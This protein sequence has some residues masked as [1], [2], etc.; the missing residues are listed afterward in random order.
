M[1]FD[2]NTAVEA[3]GQGKSN[4]VIPTTAF[5]IS[6]AQEANQNPKQKPSPIASFLRD[7]F[8]SSPLEEIQTHQYILDNK[9]KIP[10][11][12]K[13]DN[14]KTYQKKFNE[15]L[16][17]REED[18]ARE[19]VLRQVEAPMQ[20]AIGATGMAAPIETATMVG[21]FS[22]ADHFFN[23]RRWIE[24]KAP[25][26]PPV[27]KDVV[28]ILDFVAKGAVIGGGVI[29]A[30]KFALERMDNLN[31]P[32]AVTITP[33][34][35]AEI[36][37]SPTITEPLGIKPEQ[38]DASV[39]S[40]T[41]IQIPMENV[42]DL[43]SNK[44]WDKIQEK[45]FSEGKTIK[46][47]SE[48]QLLKQEKL[49]TKIVDEAGNPLEVYH[50]TQ[51]K[52]ENFDLSKAW[53]SS[54]HN[55]YDTAI[56]FS[57]DKDVAK[58]FT[59]Q[60]VRGG[61]AFIKKANLEVK[62]P[63]SVQSTKEINKDLIDKLKAEGYDGIV[64]ENSGFPN[65]PSKE[66]VVFDPSQVKSLG[67]E[68]LPVKELL[69]R[70]RSS[71]TS[72]SSEMGQKTIEQSLPKITEPKTLETNRE[73]SSES[74]PMNQIGEELLKSPEGPLPRD[75]QTSEEASQVL[76]D[77]SK[78]SQQQ[79]LPLEKSM[80]TPKIQ[81]NLKEDLS[82]GANIPPE[83]PTVK[84]GEGM[85]IDPVQK[86]IEALKAA[87]PVRNQQESIYTKE[88]AQR[89]A[90]AL[91]MRGKAGGEKGFFAE[92]SQLKGEMTK[93]EFESIRSKLNQKDIDHL[94]NMVTDEPSLGFWEQVTART[95]LGKLMG[96]HG[97]KVPTKGELALL[98]KVFGNELV[99]ALIN[100]MPFW[101]K[102]KEWTGQVLNV[103][104]SIMSS[105]DLSAPLRQGVFLVGRKEFLPAFKKMFGYFAKEENLKALNEDIAR[106]PN[107][108]L[109]KDSGLALTDMDVML[110]AREEAFMSNL[111]EKIPVVGKGI[112]ASG[113]AYVG[114]LN[115]LRADVF[116]D[117]I[118]KSSDLGLNP[119]ENRDLA[120]DI[121]MFVNTATGRG[122]L[123]G[124][125]KA[126]TQLNTIFFSP[127][128]I[129]SRLTLLNPLYYINSKPFVRNEAIKS[130]LTFTG[131]VA[132]VLALAKLSGA[133]VGT[134]IRSSDF[135]K[136]IIGRT[137]IDIM[138]GFQQYMRMIG[139][140]ATGKY[141]SSTT[142]RVVTL[143][144]GY[145]PLTRKEILVRQFESKLAPV[146]SFISTVLEG[147]TWS[148]EKVKVTEEI[149]NRLTPMVLSTLVEL[150]EEDPKLFPVGLL[151][152]FGVGV[153]TYENKK[154]KKF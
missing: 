58:L 51:S 80:N 138:G 106:S 77:V 100:K 17:P 33:E 71:A 117:L 23:A 37:R 49:D 3:Q 136:I 70:T 6:T 134:D 93:A 75:I 114:F 35:A 141:V 34:Q 144:E 61:E 127:R 50:G 154:P 74:P 2:I 42:I 79:S 68:T 103:P 38:V 69:E 11:V 130:L 8:K 145:R 25:Q 116:N 102:M 96:E 18:I 24:D 67:D 118:K 108:E 119:K 9:D 140:L 36:K 47:S 115:K 15:F 86:V 56:H 22:I 135:G 152:I 72:D 90:R 122:D 45:L 126:A 44:N 143:G 4:S 149:K 133:N 105:F 89:M 46:E 123:A 64:V 65:K 113:R 92:L 5:N 91:S 31:L 1:P 60:D 21:G 87:K 97:G 148:G 151:G 85:P 41:P 82:S 66:Y 10:K 14:Y 137:R 54:G 109:M 132:T 110:E 94:F 124:F 83:T 153:Q 12:S 7:I 150:A 40:G 131:T 112:R 81:M 88:R 76:G 48:A 78:S 39:N 84:G 73:A 99:E 57:S 43:A 98:N 139:Q 104:R 32:K 55:Q 63:Y 27:I 125:S 120:K 146:A 128:L 53:K 101:E 95:A 59:G 30:K 28:E 16:S 20:L 13:S 142:G 129:A 147:Q 121:A 107:F 111:A 19:G 52:F 29:N 62:K 26:T